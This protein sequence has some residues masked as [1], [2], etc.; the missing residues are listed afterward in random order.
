MILIVDNSSKKRKDIL[1]K[2]FHKVGIPCAV[3]NMEQLKKM[4]TARFTIAFA[5]SE[6]QLSIVSVRAGKTE[7]IVLNDTGKRM[8]NSDAHIYNP[9]SD[10]TL[11]EYVNI[12]AKEV[13]GFDAI[14]LNIPPLKF[15]GINT[16]FYEKNIILTDRE[17]MIVRHL[18]LSKGEWHSVNEIFCYSCSLGDSKSSI[19]VHIC[20]I[21]KKAVRATGCRMIIAKRGYGYKIDYTL[22]PKRE[23]SH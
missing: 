7:Y 3:V 18:I 8:F 2:Y 14:N 4:K 21:N 22:S 11:L 10:G 15:D 5:E 16:F 1:R 23:Q 20:N 9:I 19:S 17:K 6:D 12:R 13:F